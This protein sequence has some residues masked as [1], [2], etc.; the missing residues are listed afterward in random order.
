MPSKAWTTEMEKKHIGRERGATS[1]WGTAPPQ[2]SAIT[3]HMGQDPGVLSFQEGKK[4]HNMGIQFP[5]TVGGL[6]GGSFRSCLMGITGGTCGTWRL[7]LDGDG[8]EGP[9]SQQPRLRSRWAVVLLAAAPTQRSQP[10]GMHCPSAQL[11]VT[12]QGQGAQ[13]Y[14]IRAPGKRLYWSWSLQ[15]PHWGR[16]AISQSCPTAECSHQSH[17]TG[18]PWPPGAPTLAPPG[19]EA[20]QQLRRGS[21]ATQPKILQRTPGIPE[22]SRW[23]PER[24]SPA[25]SPPSP[26]V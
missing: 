18:E 14:L 20:S 11:R 10:S 5:E 17:L 24:C 8:D 19:Q 22:P 7:G 21:G 16:E 15:P 26:R 13:C 12:L 1:L 3:P 6:L 23:T 2:V 25:Y 4:E 9:G